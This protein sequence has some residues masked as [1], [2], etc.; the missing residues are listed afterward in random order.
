MS[1]SSVKQKVEPTGEDTLK[2]ENQELTKAVLALRTELFM[3][4]DELQ[5]MRNSRVLGR[6]IKTRE[7]IGDPRTL[8]R[9]TLFKVR[10]AVAKHIPDRIRLPL[11][12]SLRHTRNVVR[13]RSTQ[14]RDR[15]AKDVVIENT[16]LLAGLPLVSVVIPY[17]NRADTIDDTLQSLANQ[18]FTNF[19]VIIVDDG[20][21][22]KESID[23]LQHI[24]KAMP[25]VSVFLQK[26]QGVAAARN[27]GIKRASGRYIVCLDS[28][29]MLEPTYLEKAATVLESSP[30]IS[31][32]TAYM[33]V[34]GVVKDEFQHAAF[35]PFVLYKDNMIITAAMFRKEA[36]D[37]SGGYKSGIGYEDWEFWINLVER[38]FQAFTIPEQL[39]RYRTSMQ[40]R[41]VEDKGVHWGNLHAI[42]SL[43]PS[44]KKKVKENI[45]VDR[46]LRKTVDRQT[47]LVN[48]WQHKEIPNAKANI[49]ITTPWMTFGGAETLIYNFCR[50]LKDDY[51]ITFVTGLRSENEWEYKFREITSNI[52]HLA[53]LFTSPDLYLDY[54]SRLI[55]LN[56]IDTL[57][58]IHNGFT[59]DMLS[60]LRARH[61]RLRIIL[62]LFNDRAAYFDQSLQYAALIDTY[63]S[64]NSKVIEHFKKELGASFDFRVIP[65][66]VDSTNDFNPS[67][68]D[69]SQLRTELGLAKGD[70]AVFYVGRFSEEK[71]PNVFLDAAQEI[72]QNRPHSTSVKFFMIGDGPMR[73]I[74]EKQV[75]S[76]QT[77]RI[78]YLGY[79]SSIAH[80]LSA[81]DVFVLP[82]AIE[83]FPLSVIEAMAMEVV[84][85]ASDVGAVS[86]VIN[87][88]KDGFVITPGSV[89]EI[90]ESITRLSSNE[91]LRAEMKKASR[92]K[93]ETHYSNTT[94]ANNYR[95]LYKV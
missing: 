39:F 93:V 53:N 20:S 28:D 95:R 3:A 2:I 8:P 62:T 36:W 71:N 7:R 12:K 67:K 4:R 45:R 15:S 32:V 56:A 25:G 10:R 16:P 38:G 78:T 47:A 80:Y 86:E 76:I 58:I 23:K 40:S 91:A 60:E 9:R 73:S 52:Y 69:R 33:S 30:N 54:V 83:G 90:V 81:A 50:E 42:R 17:Y 22:E 49:L 31:I 14:Y 18:T 68:H 94:L 57:H 27:N 89:E 75:A 66:G 11:M 85:V 79:Q 74:I 43:H 37:V 59:F 72:I 1:R 87:N 77:D 35:D 61:P 82:S 84:V 48:L 5:A 51:N 26:N 55:S 19:E 41:Y 65:N 24:K 34:F 64:D 70:T 92:K 44:Y 88:G 46:L 63:T 29:D 6:I 21:S 13:M